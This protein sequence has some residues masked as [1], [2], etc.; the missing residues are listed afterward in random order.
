MTGE[1]LTPDL[2]L[3]IWYEALNQE[4][5]VTFEVI[6]R[7]AEVIKQ[8]LYTARKESG[9]PRIDELS[10]HLNQDHKTILIYH[11]TKDEALP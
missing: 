9:D 2:A 6:P 1:E 8:K 10:L 4:I 3:A 5:G 7:D 11:K